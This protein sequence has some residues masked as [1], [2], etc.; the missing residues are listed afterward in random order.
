M[1]W[2]LW[3]KQNKTKH[4]YSLRASHFSLPVCARFLY[5]FLVTESFPAL[6]RVGR[7][8]AAG[9]TISN[10]GCSPMR[11]RE[12][13]AEA[14]QSPTVL[15]SVCTHAHPRQHTIHAQGCFIFSFFLKKTQNKA[16][17]LGI[18]AQTVEQLELLGKPHYSSVFFNF[19]FYLRIEMLHC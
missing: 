8:W 9:A 19:F 15:H 7:T 4:V 10:N 1:L 3:D 5:S 6:D 2:N 14:W 17:K 12:G 16:I 13:K 18:L 11:G